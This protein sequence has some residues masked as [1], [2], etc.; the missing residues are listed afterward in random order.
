MN[1]CTRIAAT[2][3]ALVM[4]GVGHAAEDEARANTGNEPRRDAAEIVVTA[5]RNE[6]PIADAPAT[7]SVVT[8]TELRR[9][10]VQD[11]AEALE[12]EPGVAINGI[13]MTRRGI[14]IRGMSNEHVL[15][16][17]DG[18]RI[19]DAAANMAHVDFD[20]GWVPSIA[21]DRIEVVRGP[22]SAL[23][24]SEAL[25]GVIN[26][27]TRRPTERIEVSA[28]G[29]AGFRDG[30]GGD[31][32]QM[33]ALVGG[34][35]TRTLGMVAWGEYRH[36]DRTQSLADPRQSELEGRNALS[37][38]IIAWWE[39]VAGQRFEVGQAA[40][41][42]DRAR[43]T[44]TTSA[45]AT[46]YEYQDHVTRAQTHGSYTGRWRWG[47][48]R[49]RAYRSTLE[50][51]NERDRNQAPTQPTKVT[52]TVADAS[53]LLNLFRGNRLTLGGEHR[54]EALRDATVNATGFASI[55]HDALF[56]QDEW[57]IID[58][59]SFTAGSRFDHHPGYG[60]QVS[61]RAYLVVAPIEGLRFRGG[62]G[63]AFKAPSLK[64]L[65]RGY[66]TV[67]AG[68]RF[69]ITGNPDLKPETSTAYEFGASYA[70]R[71]WNVGAT[72][73]R[74]DL[75]GL[76]QTIC[77]EFCGVRGRERRAYVNVS[78]ARTQ[79]VELSAEVRPARVLTLG[80]SYTHVDPRDISANR[81]LAERPNDTVKVRLAW[82]P[83]PGTALNVR[84]R[85]IGKQTVY[86]TVGTAT[87]AVRLN[88]YDLWS[89]DAS[90]A[91]N[92]RLT[93]KAGIDN[94]FGKRLAET[95]ALYSFAEPGRV[96]FIG[97]GASF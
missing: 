60:W 95:S 27:I 83:L 9:R 81:E 58:G 19:N 63:E 5:T 32:A 10:P 90:H 68:G 23:Y 43:D 76:V 66:I 80:A 49:A 84:G 57:D 79:G 41:N 25:A 8:G 87:N 33:A 69:I 16:L 65:S 44:V 36:R 28:L 39:P 31:S 82:E 71:N 45:P 18:R 13:G 61:P 24:G 30:K 15:T 22:L 55:D 29:L 64:Q 70:G 93:L 85:Y 38:S 1:L 46:Y 20:L 73:F 3:A 51:I 78:R 14:S 67:A 50:R 75:R 86:Q 54:R 94:I 34:P 26:V 56:V 72:L 4:A 96:F 62:F 21:I 97:L 88:A 47:E 91:L 52:D 2:G 35:L 53:L 12:N 17:V 92:R 59:I 6:Q 42:D 37:G 7:M 40:I 48:L 74:N 77:V 89:L 11:L